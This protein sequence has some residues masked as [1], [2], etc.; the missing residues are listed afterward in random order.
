MMISQCR[1]YKKNQ[2]TY[3]NGRYNNFMA[4]QTLLDSSGNYKVPA[5]SLY[6]TIFCIRYDESTKEYIVNFDL[7]NR[8]DASA[9]TDNSLAVSFYNGNPET[10]GALLGIY[11]TQTKLLP[12][13]SL[14]G[15]EIRLK[16]QNLRELYLVVNSSRNN[17]GTFEDKDFILLECDYTDNFFIALIYLNWNT[18]MQKSA[19]DL[20]MIFMEDQSKI[21]EDMYTFSAA[22]RL[23]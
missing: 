18:A 10:G 2:A 16:A 17:S 6:G 13:D 22:K 15:L 11:Y 4:Q 20:P 9:Q 5:A 12:G 23:R 1:E 19:E 21:Q 3:Q 8:S 7:Y 14:I